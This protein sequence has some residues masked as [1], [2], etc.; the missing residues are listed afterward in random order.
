MELEDALKFIMEEVSKAQAKEAKQKKDGAENSENVN[1]S[2]NES[3]SQSQPKNYF[4]NIPEWAKHL[5]SAGGAVVITYLFLVKPL[6]DDLEQEKTQNAILKLQIDEIKQ[7]LAELSMPHSSDPYA[8]YNPF[9]YS[10]A[11]A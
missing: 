10:Q 11:T 1:G 6:Q 3:E 8:P 7:K 9:T 4:S 2:E 5:I